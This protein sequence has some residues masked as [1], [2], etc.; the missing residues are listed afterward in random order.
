MS[1]HKSR[2]YKDKRKKGKKKVTDQINVPNSPVQE[3]ETVL[4][5]E[6]VVTDS[7]PEL[8][9]KQRELLQ[10]IEELEHQYTQEHDKLLRQAAEFDNVRKR[11]N[12]EKQEAIDYANRNVFLDIVEIIDDFERALKAAETS[13]D[14][15]S[16]YDGIVLIER[17]FSSL[18]EN[19]WGLKRF[20]STG[21]VFDPN[22]HEALLMEKS[23]EITEPMVV[24]DLQKGYILKD[25]VIRPARVKVLM[26]E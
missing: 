20:D 24:E 16:F 12:R 11:L 18:L 8:E 4:E 15:N 7:T 14:F 6:P 5:Q 22:R 13:P 1:K 26:P 9:Q 21:Q 25:K 19:K 23:A 3:T 10:R 17:R 2:K